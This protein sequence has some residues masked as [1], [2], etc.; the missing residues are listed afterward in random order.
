MVVIFPSWFFAQLNC[1]LIKRNSFF[2]PFLGKIRICNNPC[3][4]RLSP[5]RAL[6]RQ[7]Q[8]ILNGFVVIFFQII[9][10]GNVKRY[11]LFKRII[12]FQLLKPLKSLVIFTIYIFYVRFVVKNGIAVLR[13]ARTHTV[14]V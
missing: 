3:H 1:L 9:Y 13:I 4:I 11:Y 10:L 7:W 6:F 12:I 2:V 14:E 5:V 8:S